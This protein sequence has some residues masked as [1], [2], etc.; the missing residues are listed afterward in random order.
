[1]PV[2]TSVFD[3]LREL[4]AGAERVV[5]SG[6]EQADGDAVGATA[7]LR[8]H[9]ELEGCTVTALLQEPLSPRYG[10]MEFVR[11]YEVYD[12]DRHD[13]LIRAADVFVMCDLSS[14]GRLGRLQTAVEASEAATVCV[15]HHPCEDGGPA[16][17][18]VLDPD[19]RATG[20]VIWNY[21]DHVGGRVDREIAESVF[22][23]LC[24]DT[25]WFRYPNTDAGVMKLAAQLAD[26]RLDLPEI[27]RA[28]YQSN[29]APMVRLLGHVARSMNE[30]RDGRLV[31]AFI[32]R[33]F[34]QELGVARYDA[35]PILDVLRS[36]GQVELVGLFTEREDGSVSVSL[37]SRGTP[38]V[39]LIARQYGGG[40]HVYAAGTVLA[41][42]DAVKDM[43]STLRHA[44]GGDA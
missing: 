2:A 42:E 40:G 30:E 15:D 26:Y 16:S 34:M 21:I 28:I 8:R 24:T 44:V 27:Y 3:A 23:S 22:V 17:L 25:G 4:L 33:A 12:P 18:N 38:D 29:S 32:R 31:W 35:D 20:Q 5:V 36:S 37:R 14:L 11:H 1:M 41:N 6:H 19:A 10:F 39:N 13:A 9:L 7:A 43:V